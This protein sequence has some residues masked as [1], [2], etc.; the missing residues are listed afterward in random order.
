MTTN[1]TK[2]LLFAAIATAL[3]LPAGI[4]NISA[5]KDN[6]GQEIRSLFADVDKDINDKF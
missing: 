1:N 6:Y 4:S 3:I 2:L 5:D